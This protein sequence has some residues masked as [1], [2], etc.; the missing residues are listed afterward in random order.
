MR[1][2]VII[3]CI[4]AVA[5]IAITVPFIR[6]A[7]RHWKM[8]GF[9]ALENEPDIVI[10]QKVSPAEKER[11]LKRFIHRRRLPF[12]SANS[13]W[14]RPEHHARIR[15]IIRSVGQGNVTI[16]A[17]VDKV[18]EAHFEDTGNVVESLYEDNNPEQS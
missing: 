1:E 9:G 11:Y 16:T 18:L 17:Y 8:A 12:R 4:A 5:V 7:L 10:I 14:V 15:S 6:R 13:V 2:N 3:L